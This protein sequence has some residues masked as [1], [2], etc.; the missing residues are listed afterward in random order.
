MFSTESEREQQFEGG[1]QGFG[2]KASFY[3]GP[4]YP[5]EIAPI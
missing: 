2:G 4:R 5:L 1:G 3:S